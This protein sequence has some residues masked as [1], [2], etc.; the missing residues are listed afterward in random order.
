MSHGCQAAAAALEAW[1]IERLVEPGERAGCELVEKK[2]SEDTREVGA[3]VVG[4]NAV[5]LLL[6]EFPVR[7][8]CADQ[9][10]LETR[11]LQ[12]V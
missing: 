9:G 2:S 6:G 5:P 7:V 12:A 11:E 3:M 8:A 10:E 4:L 1:S